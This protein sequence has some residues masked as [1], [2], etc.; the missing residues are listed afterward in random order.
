LVK[1]PERRDHVRNLSI[2]GWKDNIK[3]YL[4][5]MWFGLDSGCSGQDSRQAN[6]NAVMYG[7]KY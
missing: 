6:V 1:V 2:V 4:P 5:E 7:F 3:L